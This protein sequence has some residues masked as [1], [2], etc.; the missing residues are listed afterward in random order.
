MWAT[1]A[2]CGN[3]M[4]KRFLLACVAVVSLVTLSAAAKDE[5]PTEWE[6]NWP[7]WRGPLSTGVATVGNPPVEW[8]ETENVQWKLAIPGRANA[9]P[10]VWGDQIFLVTAI[11]TDRTI[12]FE[13]PPPAKVSQ[14]K[15]GYNFKKPNNF[16][17]FSVMSVDRDK[18]EIRWQTIAKEAVPHEAHHP[19]GSFASASP[20]T[21][22]KRL[23]VSFGSRGVY[24]LDM[25]GKAIWKR[26]LGR[27][28]IINAFGEGCS[29]VVH[30]D[31]LVVNWDHEDGS[32]LVCL[33]AATGEIKWKVNRDE[34][35][36]WATPLVV[37]HAGKTQ[38]VVHGAKRVRSYD[39][40]TGELLWACGGQAICP[41]PSLVN[42]GNLVF[43]MTGFRGNALYAISLDSKGDITGDEDK[44]SWKR[45]QPG[46]PY[47][48]SP[49]LYDGL[50]Y[51]TASNIG[52]LSC[53]DAKT[54]Q[55]L[56]DRQRLQGISSIYAS[57]VGA[58]NRVY[59]A[60]RF[61]A[62]VVIQREEA[63]EPFKPKTD[64]VTAEVA[65]GKHQA[66]IVATNKLDDLFDASPVIVGDQLILRGEHNLYCI[67]S[68]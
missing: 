5:L 15:A 67:S 14:A 50:L 26:D 52:I 62:T 64:G 4:M 19:D 32:F 38:V 24:C 21:D 63:P 61:G 45:N 46:T 16:Y 30:G 27:M 66:T 29:P 17:Q 47:V 34:N 1:P 51:F 40:K 23:Y 12:E 57:P 28:K 7:Q 18:G 54:G 3:F 60:G 13:E 43:A 33:D 44:I 49:L 20:T 48:P 9:T 35:T 10:V 22:G 6:Q 68:H 39:L 37:D 42:D 2:S 8:S 36:S 53:L 31:F 65:S 55:P 41:I 56:I 11:K 25:H 58:A 59:F